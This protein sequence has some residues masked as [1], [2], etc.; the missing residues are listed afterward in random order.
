MSKVTSAAAQGAS[1][2]R[3]HAWRDAHPGH[4]PRALRVTVTALPSD[5]DADSD[6]HA[7]Y[8]VERERT[9]ES[10]S[11]AARP[12]AHRV[13][14]SARS[15]PSDEGATQ[16]AARTPA[17]KRPLARNRET[18][19]RRIFTALPLAAKEP[20]A[21]PRPNYCRHHFSMLRSSSK[22]VNVSWTLS[23]EIDSVVDVVGARPVQAS[24][25]V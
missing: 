22:P 10:S 15:R 13:P 20:P 11:P 23:V 18:R 19:S 16:G 8:F 17:E 21:Q 5:A 7:H 24:R 3:T 14:R 1:N 6:R 4:C 12:L 9:A 2:A 25:A